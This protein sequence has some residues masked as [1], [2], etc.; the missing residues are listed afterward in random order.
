MPW[1][2]FLALGLLSLGRFALAAADRPS[3]CSNQTYQ[4]ISDKSSAAIPRVAGCAHAPGNADVATVPVSPTVARAS[5]DNS[6]NVSR[7]VR[8]GPTGKSTVRVDDGRWTI[9]LQGGDDWLSL[10]SAATLQSRSIR[11]QI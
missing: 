4:A 2:Y 10:R 7:T 11:L 1:Y 3:A 8:F 6:R 5:T 9:R